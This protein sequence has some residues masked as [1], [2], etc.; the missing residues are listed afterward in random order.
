VHDATAQPDTFRIGGGAAKHARCFG[1][2]IGALCRIFGSLALVLR[3][4]WVGGLLVAAALG[5]QWNRNEASGPEN[6][7]SKNAR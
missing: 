7:E 3:A 2:L 6:A 4:G 1:K 5:E